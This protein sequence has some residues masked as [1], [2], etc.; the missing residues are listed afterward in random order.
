MKKRAMRQICE[1]MC[2]NTGFDPDEIMEIIKKE[3]ARDEKIR[4]MGMREQLR[5]PEVI[6][7]MPK[8]D[9]EF[10]AYFV[11]FCERYENADRKEHT[12]IR[13]PTQAKYF[14]SLLK[15]EAKRFINEE[16]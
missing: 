2:K 8:T 5:N 4:N 11:M 15:K 10:F 3:Q 1:E 14:D 16:E 6:L 9:K 13:S 7:T 12:I